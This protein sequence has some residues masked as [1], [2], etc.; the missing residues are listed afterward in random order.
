MYQFFFFFFFFFFGGGGGGPNYLSEIL[1]NVFHLS[2]VTTP[3]I[4]SCYIHIIMFI[5][6]YI[7]TQR[8]RLFLKRLI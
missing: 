1:G 4:I 6:I 8:L 7:I 3:I 5:I 2:N